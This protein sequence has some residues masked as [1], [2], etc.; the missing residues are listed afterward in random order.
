AQLRGLHLRPGGHE[1]EVS[2]TFCAPDPT[3]SPPEA[4]SLKTAWPD[5]SVLD[6]VVRRVVEVAHPERIILF[7]SAARGQAGPDSD[8]DL[9][10]IKSGITRPRWLAGE[11]HV[12]MFGLPVS[13]DIVV[14]TPEDIERF[15]DKVGSIVRPALREGREIYVAGAT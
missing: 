12:R 10:V 4:A 8:L 13:M 7:G 1:A 11:I 9:L 14:V 5:Q 15:R 3:V 2:E 6:E